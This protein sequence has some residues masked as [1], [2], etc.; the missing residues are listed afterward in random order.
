[1]FSSLEPWFPEN[2]FEVRPLVCVKPM[3]WS[4]HCHLTSHLLQ[5]GGPFVVGNSKVG[6]HFERTY[7]YVFK[8]RMQRFLGIYQQGICVIKG[9]PMLNGQLGRK[10][11]QFPKRL[12]NTLTYRVH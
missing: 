5:E 8:T 3:N 10:P 9:E 12:L 1:L 4:K 6:N 11:V 7:S 2:I